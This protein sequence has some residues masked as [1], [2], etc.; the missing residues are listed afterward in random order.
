MATLLRSARSGSDWTTND[1]RACNITVSSQIP[2]RFY[3]LALPAVASLTNI[4][5]NLLSST[6]STKGLSNETH[7]LLQYLDLSSRA[8]SGQES[9][10]HDFAREILRALGYEV[11]DF[12]LRTRYT[13]PL[14]I[15]GDPNRSVQ[16]SVCLVHAFMARPAPL[17][18][19]WSK[20][21]STPIRK[22][23]LRP[24]RL[25]STIIGSEHDWVKRNLS[26]RSFHALQ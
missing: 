23:S 11:R 21:R 6:F 16:T 14:S 18:Y 24:S 13:I 10:D 4:D 8:N 22:S 9:A 15:S 2:E 20:P 7:R 26:L 19:Q 1:L 17:R 25:S 3:G 12:L 5:P